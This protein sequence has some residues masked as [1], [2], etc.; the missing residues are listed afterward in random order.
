LLL[1]IDK[2]TT[3][4]DK[5]NSRLDSIKKAIKA[6]TAPAAASVSVPVPLPLPY[7]APP[8]G[9]ANAVKKLV[10]N[11]PMR[12]VPR[13]PPVNQ[14][15]NEFKSSFFVICETVPKYRPFFQMTPDQITKKVNQVLR[16]I[17]PKAQDG[18]PIIIKGSATLPSGDFKF[19]TQTC[20][21]ANWFLEKKHKW[22]HLCNPNLVTPPLIFPVI[23]HLVPTT[24]K[25]D[26]QSM[27][28]DLCNEN[29]LDIKEIHSV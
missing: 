1:G 27:I 12:V 21:A 24:F 18:A 19:F 15:I 22:T 9:W 13:L 28:Q 8:N 23:L 25:P 7:Q 6:V 26:N 17:N 14:V 29:N 5:M 11:V 16:E 4:I 2:L 10:N 3:S 20:F